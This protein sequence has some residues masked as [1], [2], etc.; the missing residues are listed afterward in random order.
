MAFHS[1]GLWKQIVLEER[2]KLS[3]PNQDKEL[4]F[5]DVG[6]WTS[7]M[8]FLYNSFSALVLV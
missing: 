3:G 2:D 1:G 4:T 8:K 5:Q 6:E 7:S